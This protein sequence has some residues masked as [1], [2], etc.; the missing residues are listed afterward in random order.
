[1]LR[2]MSDH[3]LTVPHAS[4]R[5]TCSSS[6]TRAGATAVE[7]DALAGRAAVKCPD[8]VAARGCDCVISNAAPPGDRPPGGRPIAGPAAGVGGARG[9]GSGR[10]GPAPFS[11]TSFG[12]FCQ[13]PLAAVAP[14]VQSLRSHRPHG[15]HGRSGRAAARDGRCPS[16]SCRESG[17]RSGADQGRDGGHGPRPQTA[18]NAGALQARRGGNSLRASPP[19]RGKSR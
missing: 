13:Q 7:A 12:L 6:L 5:D 2:T 19:R 16:R 4:P 9:E 14:L 1:M 15:R 17:A 11:V 18:Y 3:D 10:A 8:L